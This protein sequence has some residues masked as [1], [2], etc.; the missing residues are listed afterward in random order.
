MC[1]H[2]YTHVITENHRLVSLGYITVVQS[3]LATLSVIIVLQAVVLQNQNLPG[4][5]LLR[6]KGN[7]GM[8]FCSLIAMITTPIA[9]L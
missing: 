7:L 8:S 5:Y 3:Y 6:K 2:K 9:T 1:A 4:V